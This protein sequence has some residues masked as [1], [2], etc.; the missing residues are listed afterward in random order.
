VIDVIELRD[1]RCEVIVGLL[2]YERETVQPIALDFDIRRSFERAAQSDD[3]TH[4]TNYALIITLAEKIA[5]EG[6]F[7]LLETLVSRIAEAIL[8]FDSEVDAV[9]VAVRKLQ[10]PVPEN[11][12]TVGVRTTL[13]R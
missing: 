8:E 1:L 13:T 6:K 10:P 2:E 9:T 3:V 12:A 11:I 7:L 4:T 5:R